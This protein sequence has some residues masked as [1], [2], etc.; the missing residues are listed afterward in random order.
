[1][2]SQFLIYLLN[3]SAEA[4]FWAFFTY[5]NCEYSHVAAERVWKC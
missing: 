5:T 1:M 4:V 3:F 2:G